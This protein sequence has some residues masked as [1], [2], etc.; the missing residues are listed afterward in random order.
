MKMGLLEDASLLHTGAA[1]R[2]L[3]PMP[4]CLAAFLIIPDFSYTIFSNFDAFIL[5]SWHSEIFWVCSMCD[6]KLGVIFKAWRFIHWHGTWYWC[7]VGMGRE[8]MYCCW[9]NFSERQFVMKRCRELVFW[10][11]A[12]KL[13]EFGKIARQMRNMEE[14]ILVRIIRSIYKEIVNSCE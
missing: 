8:Y 2:P 11:A 9:P 13:M 5:F 3:N 1:S 7:W 12:A 4:V 14:Q 10:A 6:T